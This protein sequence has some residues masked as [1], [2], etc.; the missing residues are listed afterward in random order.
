MGALWATS[1][2]LI[3]FTVDCV[4]QGEVVVARFPVW[5]PED[6]KTE[7]GASQ[8]LVGRLLFGDGSQRMLAAM[9]V[10]ICLLLIWRSHPVESL[11]TPM[12]QE[13]IQS[14]LQVS[15]LVKASEATS[16]NLEN[17][18][19]RIASQNLAARVQPVSTFQMAAILQ[20]F[21]GES[22]EVASLDIAISL[23]NGHP[24]V[25]SS[26]RTESGTGSVSLDSRKK[27]GSP[28]LAGAVH[29]RSFRGC[30]AILPRCAIRFGCVWRSFFLQQSVLYGL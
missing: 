7:H 29:A 28:Q 2:W 11:K 17:M 27:A 15:T 21:V 16:S 22:R 23:Y 12:V 1:K 26:D 14:F 9:S 20:S 30:A 18:V 6:L 10:W 13:L 8:S 3:I 5:P 4:C 24:L 25:L 19:T